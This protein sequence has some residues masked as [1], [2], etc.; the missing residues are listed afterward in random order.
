MCDSKNKIE[1]NQDYFIKHIHGE[2]LKINK[3]LTEVDSVVYD[4]PKLFN[5]WQKIRDANLK[6]DEIIKAIE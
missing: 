6:L 2:L 5:E 1:V 3:V 4:I